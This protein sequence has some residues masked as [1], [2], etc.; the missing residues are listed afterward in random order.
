[1]LLCFFLPLLIYTVHIY[2][3]RILS[4]W[5][6]CYASFGMLHNVQCQR[7]YY[8]VISQGNRIFVLAG[9]RGTVIVKVF[10]TWVR[11]WAHALSPV[12]AVSDGSGTTRSLAASTSWEVKTPA[13]LF[14]DCFS[15]V[16]ASFHASLS[17]CPSCFNRNSW[18]GEQWELRTEQSRLNWHHHSNWPIKEKVGS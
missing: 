8:F 16:A 11:F 6:C 13:R 9:R 12:P 4:D 7:F 5:K 15:C 14:R 3:L 2:A 1:M 18:W 10:C 17:Q